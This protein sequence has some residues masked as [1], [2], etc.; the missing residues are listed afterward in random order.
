MVVVVEQSKEG[1][2]NHHQNPFF[3][4]VG[5]NEDSIYKQ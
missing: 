4:V 1:Q 5:N 3:G 2:I